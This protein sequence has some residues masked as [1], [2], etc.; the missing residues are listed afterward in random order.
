MNLNNII[1]GTANFTQ[2]YGFEKNKF[3][4]LN[5]LFKKIKKITKTSKKE[6]YLDC[7]QAYG[8]SLLAIGKHNKDIKIKYIVKILLNTKE[9]INFNFIKKKVLKS[10]S[11]LKISQMYCLMLH[12]TKVLQNKKKMKIVL[13]S[14]NK[15]K[16]EKY[17]KKKGISI[18]NLKE[19]N[20]IYS[21][22]KPDIIQLSSNIFDQ[23]FVQS[24][25]V[26]K[27]KKDKKEI[28]IRSIFLQGLLLK[29][30]IPIK[31][32]HFKIEFEK[33]FSWLKKNSISP[34]DACLNFVLQQK[35]NAKFIIGLNNCDQLNQIVKFKKNK[36]K[37]NFM[38]LASNKDKLIN[39]TNWL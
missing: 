18:Y 3:T 11:D 7:A 13:E 2:R 10:L 20:N 30:K 8:S 26:K 27:F 35:I 32:L 23:R 6:I 4:N 9:K 31:F 34:Y 14:L 24:R 21:T 33:W 36:K 12:D 22:F 5:K 17:I 25:W 37:L 15:L 29:K 28:H 1:I 19:L 39:P 38:E 16:K